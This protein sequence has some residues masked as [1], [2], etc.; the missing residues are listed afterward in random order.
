M[1]INA[2]VNHAID[3]WNAATPPADWA[4]LRDRWE[5]GHALRA[6]VGLVGL[7]TTL[8][9]LAMSARGPGREPHR[10]QSPRSLV[11]LGLLA[12][13]AAPACASPKASGATCPPSSTLT[14]E[15]FG[16]AFFETNCN[17]CHSSTTKGESPLFDDVASIRAHRASIDEQAAA[18]PSSTNDGMPDD[19]DLAKAERE[20]LGQWLACGA[21]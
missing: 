5:L 16:K 11:G 19:G 15:S 4:A 21:P 8:L 14:Y 3:T 2:P 20:K 7:G 17:G 18:G 12:V 1:L 13:L 10:E 9:N 6:Y